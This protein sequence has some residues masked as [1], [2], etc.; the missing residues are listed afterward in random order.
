MSE[1]GAESPQKNAVAPAS[2]ERRSLVI[3]CPSRDLAYSISLSKEFGV[4]TTTADF[5]QFNTGD[6]LKS[7]AKWIDLSDSETIWR[8]QA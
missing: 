7:A 1:N 8:D 2:N 3:V 4:E 5:G 6:I